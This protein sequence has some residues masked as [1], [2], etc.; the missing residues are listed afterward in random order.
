MTIA[1]IG[2]CSPPG[3]VGKTIARDACVKVVVR[4]GCNV[5][6]STNSMRPAVGRGQSGRTCAAGASSANEHGGS[7]IMP[8]KWMTPDVAP[9]K[10]R[11]EARSDAPRT[12][13]AA[14]TRCF[15]TGSRVAAH[16]G[17]AARTAARQRGD[18]E[19]VNGNGIGPL[20]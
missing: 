15:M 17:G 12:N 6:A 8:E 19:Y 13:D 18:A 10:D 5:A 3:R 2:V 1:I 7:T 14:V 16:R 9:A 11:D 4:T 20:E